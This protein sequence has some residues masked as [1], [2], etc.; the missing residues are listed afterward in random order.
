MR[1]LSLGGEAR[2][3]YPPED[4][5]EE[6]V[7][8]EEA[9]QRQAIDLCDARPYATGIVVGWGGMVWRVSNQ[10]VRGGEGV[11]E[12]WQRGKHWPQNPCQ[13]AI[14]CPGMPVRKEVAKSTQAR[15]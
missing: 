14:S 12:Q 13:T 3:A 10:G 11:V 15:N 8:Q 9:H 7:H 2:P 1:L 5:E 6:D 4:H